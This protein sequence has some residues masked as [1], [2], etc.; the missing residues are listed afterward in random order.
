M[1][2]TGQPIYQKG[3]KPAKSAPIREA[4]RDAECQ[5]NIPG[6]CRNDPA[7]VVFCHLRLFGIAGT[8]QKPDDLIGY[9]G[10]DR[11]HAVQED[12]SRWADAAI[13][14]EDVLRAMIKSQ[15]ARRAAGLISLKGEQ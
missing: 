12:R 14:F 15:L 5:L 10:C 3:A 8:A 6:V 4:A 11:C 1:N 13:G 2:L 7:H 9:D